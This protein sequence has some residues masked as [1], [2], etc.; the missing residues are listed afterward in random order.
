MKILITGIN[1]QLGKSLIDYAPRNYNLLKPN[2]K[3]LNLADKEN[4]FEYIIKNKPDWIIN[5]A[6][7]TNVDKAEKEIDLTLKINSEAPISFANALK[8]V[9]G[10]ILQISTDYVFNGKSNSPYTPYSERNPINV[11]GLSKSL[12]EEGLEKILFKSKQA[13]ILRTSWLIGPYKDN[14]LRKM[15]EFHQNKESMNIVFDQISSPT[16]TLSLAKTCWQIISNNI[17]NS[18]VIE[19]P[20]LHWSDLGIASWYDLA[21][22]I[23]ETGM[24]IGLLTQKAKVNPIT[25]DQYTT[26]AKR[27]NYSL[28]D[29]R[30]TRSLFNLSNDHWQTEIIRICNKIKMSKNYLK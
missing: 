22:F 12:A 21:F 10:K 16:S 30:L 17:D 28:L 8:I 9:G 25:S 23:G 20:I 15:L 24:N 2:K 29:S 5:C 27:P 18:N 4:C 6:A 14:F 1:G 26:E 7:Y 11:Y 19:Q 3:L 13:I